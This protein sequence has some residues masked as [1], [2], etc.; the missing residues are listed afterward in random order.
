METIKNNIKNLHKNKPVRVILATLLFVII[1]LTAFQAGMFVGYQKASFSNGLG[2]KYYKQ[3][4]EGDKR[5]GPFDFLGQDLPGG[6]G[7][8]GK[9][10]RIDLPSNSI[11][12][13]T[14]DNIEKTIRVNDETLIR[15]F[16]NKISIKDLNVGEQ[17]IALGSPDYKGEIKAKLIRLVPPPPNEIG[18]STL[19]ATGTL[20]NPTQ[21]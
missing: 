3:A 12:V 14:P 10:I 1:I 8:T 11:L 5:G 18:T 9:I 6:S 2:K 16:R 13:A 17:I 21:Q 19:N 4:F 20:Q 15:K 7:A